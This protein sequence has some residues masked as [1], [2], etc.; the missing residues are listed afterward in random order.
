[1]ESSFIFLVPESFRDAR[2]H[3][4]ASD[5]TQADSKNPTVHVNYF[6]SAIYGRWFLLR[7]PACAGRGADTGSANLYGRGTA[8]NGAFVK[9]STAVD[10]SKS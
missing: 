7:H 9:D 1:M 4:D 6:P 2:D 3:C 10:E 8:H 5:C